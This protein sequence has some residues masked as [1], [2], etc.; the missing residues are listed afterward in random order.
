VPL[1]A[2]LK[3]ELARPGFDDIVA[4]QRAHASLEDEAV[5]VLARVT[6]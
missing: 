2:R 3:D 6:V 5:L 1:V 4:E